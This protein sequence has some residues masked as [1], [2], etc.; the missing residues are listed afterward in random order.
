MPL[1]SLPN[2]LLLLIAKRLRPKPLSALLRTTRAL[3]NLLTPLLL[4]G[5]ASE[6]YTARALEKHTPLDSASE[7][8]ALE[9]VLAPLLLDVGASES[10]TTWHTALYWAARHGRVELVT[11]L[12]VRGASVTDIGVPD[13]STALHWAARSGSEPTLCV[14]L[15]HNRGCINAPD[16]GGDTPIF[17]AAEA[18][19]EHIVRVLAEQGARLENLRGQMLLHEAICAGRPGVA[20]VLLDTGADMHVYDQF[21]WLPLHCAARHGDEVTLV[22]L[23]EL[24]AQ[25]DALQLGSGGTALHWAA[26]GGHAGVVRELVGRGASVKVRDACGATPFHW[27]AFCGKAE[28]AES[29]LQCGA[30]I[31]AVCAE[32]GN[33]ALHLAL[34]KNDEA[35]DAVVEMLLARTSGPDLN[36]KNNA[37]ATPLAWPVFSGSRNSVQRMLHG[38]ADMFVRD[39]AGWTVL[40]CAED[41][42][43]IAMIKTLVR[44]GTRGKRQAG[45]LNL[46]AFWRVVPRL[47]KEPF[48]Q[49]RR[50]KRVPL[51]AA[52]CRAGPTHVPARPWLQ[53]P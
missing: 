16:R 4:D 48:D 43:D 40:D 52:T 37:G 11:A 27:A 28:A 33:T 10:Y 5:G 23:L 6:S 15:D 31:N 3:A 7:S 9:N 39:N 25:V 44:F 20:G 19:H 21:G 1:L 26:E 8:Q 51:R 22:R 45:S 49:R 46:R 2:E 24:Q 18:G 50:E 47:V 14:L 12:L 42:L 30:D 41:R 34:S 29:L 32:D 36:A 38:G 13:H 17:W 35:H 53:I